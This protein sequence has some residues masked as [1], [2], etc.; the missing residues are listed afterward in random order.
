[1]FKVEI[2]S[3]SNLICFA[4]KDYFC[5]VVCCAS[6]LKIAIWF[7]LSV[8]L[9]LKQIRNS[10]FLR[11]TRDAVVL[12]VTYVFLPGDLRIRGKMSWL[13][14]FRIARIWFREA[15][16]LAR[17][18]TYI[19]VTTLW[20]LI[21]QILRNFIYFLRLRTYDFAYGNSNCYALI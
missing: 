2:V 16:F 5:T 14:Y 9:S 6:T 20:H 13:P 8:K 3:A 18:R 4:L 19:C 15:K 11:S 21:F 12:H 1:M 17:D 7:F 10:W